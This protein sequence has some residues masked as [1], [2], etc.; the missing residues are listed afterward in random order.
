[1]QKKYNLLF[2]LIFV[3]QMLQV[4]KA[5]V[6]LKPGDVLLI[7]LRCY[8]CSIIADETDSRFSHSAVVLGNLDNQ[9]IVA[10]ALGQVHALPLDRF[11]AQKKAGT[12]ILVRRPHQSLEQNDLMQEFVDH[13]M[14][15]PF[16][17]AYTWDDEKLYCSEFVTKFL[18]VFLGAVFPPAPLD[19]SRNWDYWSRVMDPV[20][21]GELGN[22]PG[23]L[24]RSTELETVGE[25]F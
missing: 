3:L 8:S 15:R 21:Q 23:D 19:F 9:V 17:S 16:D 12:S 13:W 7:E 22:S 25:I 18:E 14:D 4:A 2:L 6:K 1:M 11:V 10:Q 5:Q 20:P 24:E